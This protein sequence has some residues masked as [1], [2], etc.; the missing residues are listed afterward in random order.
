VGDGDEGGA[1]GEAL[2]PA[3]R[4]MSGGITV[5]IAAVV[6]FVRGGIKRAERKT[7]VV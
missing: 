2:N 5:A 3:G 4:P 1:G 6:S 7:T